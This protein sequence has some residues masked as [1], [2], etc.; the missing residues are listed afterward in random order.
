MNLEIPITNG[1]LQKVAELDH[2]RGSWTE[3]RGIPA[4]R[5]QALREVVLVQ[6]VASSCRLGG[7]RLSDDEVA[8]VLRDRS[9]SARDRR[10][11]LGYSAARSRSPWDRDGLLTCATLRVFHAVLTGADDASAEA[12]PWRREPTY[13]EAFDAEGRAT[14]RVFQTLPPRM[15]PDKV[16]E[17]LTWLEFELRKG[18]S[19]PLLVVGTCMLV[20]LAASPFDTGNGRM[21]RLLAY[22]LLQRAGYRHL[23]YASLERVMEETREGYYEA[24]DQATTGIWAGRANLLPWLTYFLETLGEQRR[25]VKSAIDL[26]LR[27]SNLSPLQR[28]V[29][30]T[31][32]EHGVADAALLLAATGANR[33]TLKDNMRRLVALGLVERTGERRGTRYRLGGRLPRTFVPPSSKWV[34]AERAQDLPSRKAEK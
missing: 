10:E 24:F 34:A 18:E 20:F 4:D 19:H 8:T 11:I 12:S 22:H 7:L 23:E 9:G 15:L 6:S 17:L 2:F 13:R 5:L 33:N 14:G 32:R 1:V 16:D 27:A 29:V 31:L 28:A 30:N 3:G 26:E 21:G 25:R